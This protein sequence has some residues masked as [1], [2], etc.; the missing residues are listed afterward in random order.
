MPENDNLKPDGEIKLTGKQLMES[1][2]ME[3]IAADVI[4]QNKIEMGPA[5]SW[6]PACLSKYFKTESGQMYEGN[7]RS[8]STTQA[9]IIL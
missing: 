3:K 4:K 8:E 9:M 7:K 2:D 1:P 6:I 5:E